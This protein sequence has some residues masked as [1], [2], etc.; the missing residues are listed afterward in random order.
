[1]RKLDG[2][3]DAVTGGGRGVGPATARQFIAE[4]AR[5]IIAGRR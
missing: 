3:T 2:K 1:M 5:V 4:G